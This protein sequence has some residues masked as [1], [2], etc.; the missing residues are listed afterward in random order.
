MGPLGAVI[1]VASLFGGGETVLLDFYSDTC[2][3]CRAMD[4]V[5]QQLASQGYPI[6]KVN[7]QR[8]PGLAARFG[9]RGVPCFV[10]LVDGREADRVVGATSLGRLKQMLSLGRPRAS[11][12]ASGPANPFAPPQAPTIPQA[13]SRAHAVPLPAEISDR[14]FAASTVAPPSP[15][16]RVAPAGMNEAAGQD[17]AQFEADLIACTVRLRIQDATGHSCGSGTLVDARGGEA[18]ILT[19]GHLFRDSQGKGRIEVDLFGSY[20]AERI[21]GELL[22]FDLEKDLALLR[23]R[24]NGPVRTARIAPPGYRIAKGARVV[25]VGCNNGEPP[26]VRYAHITALDKFLGPANIEVSGLPV[27][28]RSGGGLFTADGLVIGVCNAAVPTDNEGMYAALDSIHAELDQANLAFVYRE[29]SQV[30]A[31]GGARLVSAAQEAPGQAHPAAMDLAAAGPPSMPKKMPPPSDLVQLTDAPGQPGG[32]AAPPPRDANVTM[33]DQAISPDEQAALEEIHRR[34]AEGA[35]V[36][37]IIRSRTDPQR[38]SE[39]IMLDR[40]SPL[41][42]RQLTN[43]P[44]PSEAGRDDRPSSEQPPR[45]QASSASASSTARSAAPLGRGSGVYPSQAGSSSEWS[46]R[47]LASGYQGS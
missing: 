44:A 19:C 1:L 8:E 46:P 36:I 30:A 34:K 26:T 16:D 47:W 2:P 14:T 10:M 12:I 35:E 38:K 37:L 25:N 17:Q 29:P 11:T 33:G 22:H 18:L 39:V 13:D 32:L 9:V 45:D 24:V 15:S 20:P 23:I 41:F 31:S 43:E 28:G 21:P 4:P 40:V 27:Q 42:L 6:R 5:V 7:V 3:P